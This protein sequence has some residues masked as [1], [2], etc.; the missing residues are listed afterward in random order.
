MTNSSDV[1]NVFNQALGKIIRGPAN[2]L[3]TGS[4]A[5]VVY[6]FDSGGEC[7]LRLATLGCLE[8]ETEGHEIVLDFIGGTPDDHIMV[9]GLLFNIS[10]SF[11]QNWDQISEFGVSPVTVD[12]R[13]KEL[14]NFSSIILVRLDESDFEGIDMFLAGKRL[15]LW[16]VAS[17]SKE[18]YCLMYTEGFD[19]L[20]NKLEQVGCQMAVYKSRD[21][22]V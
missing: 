16:S 15:V 21:S 12:D 20:A 17:V 7:D 19:V 6:E 9:P 14:L 22:A 18:E 13:Y 4:A 5:C 11:V 10:D 1:P 8:T 2:R 3:V